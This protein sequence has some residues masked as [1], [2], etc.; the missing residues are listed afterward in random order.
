M[1]NATQGGPAPHTLHTH[2]EARRAECVCRAY[3]TRSRGSAEEGRWW[4]NSIPHAHTRGYICREASTEQTTLDT[5]HPR[6]TLLIGC[7]KQQSSSNHTLTHKLTAPA[8]RREHNARVHRQTQLGKQFSSLGMRTTKHTRTHTAVVAHSTLK[9]RSPT[10]SQLTRETHTQPAPNADYTQ[11]SDCNCLQAPQETP[12]LTTK[13][14]A[15]TQNPPCLCPHITG[16]GTAA[17]R[18]ERALWVGVPR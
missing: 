13:P 1:L 15:H 12:T 10:R 2:W 17:M 8:P 14:R 6:S 9:V 7:S 11:L 3:T 4:G 16:L 5:P 18:K